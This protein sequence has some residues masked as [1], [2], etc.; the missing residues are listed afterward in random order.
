MSHLVHLHA[1]N[2]YQL[3]FLRQEVASLFL[4]LALTVEPL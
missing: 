1:F 3:I 4:M 2:I